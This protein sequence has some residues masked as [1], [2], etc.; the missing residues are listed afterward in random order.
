MCQYIALRLDALVELS[1][2]GSDTSYIFIEGLT[3]NE[4]GGS[5]WA[6]R[7]LFKGSLD[8]N[9]N[10]CLNVVEDE[11]IL[12]GKL[13]TLLLVKPKRH[14]TCKCA[15]DC[16][17]F[18]YDLE[19]WEKVEYF[20]ILSEV[21]G[22]AATTEFSPNKVFLLGNNAYHFDGVILLRNPRNEK[23]PHVILFQVKHRVSLEE[24][25]AHSSFTYD[26]IK[27]WHDD[28]DKAVGVW[29]KRDNASMDD[30]E[31]QERMKNVYYLFITTKTVYLFNRGVDNSE[32]SNGMLSEI[33]KTIPRMVIIDKKG[34]EKF[35]GRTFASHIL[36][37]AHKTGNETKIEELHRKKRAQKLETMTKRLSPHKRF[38]LM[39]PEEL[40]NNPILFE[41]SKIHPYN[42]TYNTYIM[43]TL[44]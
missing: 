30:K 3:K 7:E 35:L 24:D 22:S 28:A 40:Y 33:Q 25:K 10:Q 21:F 18:P 38:Q 20:D 43:H 8:Y 14:E 29:V 27:K 4:T 2:Y 9:F 19:T 31:V 1:K 26:E 17:N 13:K 41:P 5:D 15:A 44:F 34:L 32:L 11:Q 39:F 16:P 12:C 37:K 6:L 36:M 23:R 42:H